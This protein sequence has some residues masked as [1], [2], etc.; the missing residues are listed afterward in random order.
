MV[1]SGWKEIA[2]YLHCGVRTVQRWEAEALPVHRP[3]PGKRSHVIAYSDELDWWVRD[4]QPRKAVP[5]NVIVS[6]HR[7]QRLREEARRARAELRSRMQKLREEM[8]SL[9]GHRRKTV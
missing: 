9:R 6:V 2:S 4:H 1:L 3:L 8:A 5:E 7:A